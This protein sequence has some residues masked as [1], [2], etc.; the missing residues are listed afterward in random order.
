MEKL[1]KNVNGTDIE[2][3]A[4][5]YQ[6]Y[7]EQQSL[8]EEQRIERKIKEYTEALELKVNQTAAEKTYS[9]GIS[10]ASYVA[11][12]NAQW[13]SE[14]QAFVAWRDAVYA[15]ALTILNQVQSGEIQDLSLEDFI[16]SLPQMVWPT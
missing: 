3:T 13:A 7:Y 1:Y 6:E 2:L 14:A 9:S 15:Y 5:E 12:T 8:W 11:S 10:C 4:S 16:S